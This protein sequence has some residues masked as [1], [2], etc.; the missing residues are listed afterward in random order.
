MMRQKS[1][2]GMA[3]GSDSSLWV[4]PPPLPGLCSS[5]G[6]TSSTSLFPQV[7]P[8]STMAFSISSM[9]RGCSFAP[10]PTPP[11]PTRLWDLMSHGRPKPAPAPTPAY[12]TVVSLQVRKHSSPSAPTTSVR[13]S[14][15]SAPKSTSA[16]FSALPPTPQPPSKPP[17]LKWW[18]LVPSL[19]VPPAARPSHTDRDQGQVPPPSNLPVLQE[20]GTPSEAQ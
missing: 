19:F 4:V 15:S 12:T 3:C 10:L 1:S 16:T 9:P 6:P 7:G 2:P 11:L 5:T 18:W 14:P 20:G 17:S 8:P 13:R